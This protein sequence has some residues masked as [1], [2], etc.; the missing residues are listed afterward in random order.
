[1]KEMGSLH[2]GRSMIQIPH[3]RMG[4]EDITTKQEEWGGQ[5]IMAGS[6]TGR[7]SRNKTSV[8][9]FELDV[10]RVREKRT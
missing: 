9:A 7:Y 2:T 4:R 3:A 8:G 10:V 1:M 5:T 6:K